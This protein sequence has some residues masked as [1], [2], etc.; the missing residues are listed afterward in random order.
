MKETTTKQ[1]PRNNSIFHDR[2]LFMAE[3]ENLFVD[4]WI[5]VGTDEPL[6]T[7]GTW[8]VYE[9]FERSLLITRDQDGK[10]CAFNNACT[11]R[12]TRL[13]RRSGSGRQIQCPY[14]GW[15]YDLSGRLSGVPRRKG[16]GD[17][18]D[19]DFKLQSITV[20]QVGR[21]I[22]VHPGRRAETKLRNYLGSM[23][24][25]LE[26][27]SSQMV[28]HIG[29]LRLD[30]HANWKLVVSGMIEDYHTPFVHPKS[31]E[32][33]RASASQSDLRESGHSFYE[34]EISTSVWIRRIVRLIS[35]KKPTENHFN[36]LLFPNLIPTSS[37]N[38]L[39]VNLFIPT[40]PDRTL[41]LVNAYDHSKARTLLR[42]LGWMQRGLW[43]VALDRTRQIYVEDN[44]V[45]EEAQC[46]TLAGDNIL[47]GPPHVEEARVEHFLQAVAE[48]TGY[49]Y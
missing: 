30:I 16:C 11:H 31:L 5:C 20:D 29:D 13:C 39:T 40:A 27:F 17:F 45:I 32:T 6:Q 38:I 12:G 21:F 49:Y 36:Y 44:E 37:L 19:K 46:G 3:Q 24:K 15:T 41:L 18:E 26:D 9:D 14:H 1:Y 4:G 10:I 25:F 48:R 2:D 28:T 43:K 22:F 47:R 7:A 33:S 35:G 8:F 34:V 23:T 42:P